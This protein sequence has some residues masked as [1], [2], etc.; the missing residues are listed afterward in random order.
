MY[1][2]SNKLF[3]ILSR[4]NLITS[5]FPK[6]CH[7][8]PDSRPLESGDIINVD[9]TVFKDGFHGD[10]SKTF[11]VNYLKKRIKA[12]FSTFKYFSQLW[13][14]FFFGFFPAVAPFYFEKVKSRTMVFKYLRCN[15]SVQFCWI[16]YVQYTGQCIYFSFTVLFISL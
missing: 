4:K 7:G 15:S 6:V 13:A 5:T 8:I 2:T 14:Y 12:N 16:F 11:L 9:I 1:K 3:F 10:C